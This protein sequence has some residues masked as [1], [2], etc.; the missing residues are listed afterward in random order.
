MRG[1]LLI[2][3][4]LLAAGGAGVVLCRLMGIDPQLTA[5]SAAALG[6][7]IA[8]ALA[9]G[10][11]FLAGGGSQAAAAQAG[12]LSTGVHLLGHA[13]VAGIVIVGHLAV[14]GGFVYWLMAFYMVTLI[15]VCGS[16]VSVIRRAPAERAASASG[17][18][19]P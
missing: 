13:A 16:L 18:G 5:M 15:V 11:L 9:A 4:V 19:K 10:P 17:S 14:G 12:L 2:P 1:F 3:I 8:S 7:L 6:S